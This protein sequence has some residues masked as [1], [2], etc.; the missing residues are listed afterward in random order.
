MAKFNNDLLATLKL[1]TDVE[2]WDR[3]L[4]KFVISNKDLYDRPATCLSIMSNVVVV[5]AEQMFSIKGVYYTA[6]SDLF[7]E[8]PEGLI[9]PEYHI[10]LKNGLFYS[11]ERSD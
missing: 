7:D 1:D 2:K 3:R 6:L 5:R 9:V 8:L 11:F 10:N 4:G